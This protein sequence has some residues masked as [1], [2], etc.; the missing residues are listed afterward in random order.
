MWSARSDERGLS[1]TIASGPLQQSFSGTSPVGLMTIFYCLRFETPPR[2]RIYIP[3]KQDGPIILSGTGF[4]FVASYDSQG[5]GS[6]GSGLELGEC[7]VGH[8]PLSRL[9]FMYASF[10]IL[11]QFPSSDVRDLVIETSPFQQAQQTSILSPLQFKIKKKIQ[12]P[13]SQSMRNA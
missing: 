13:K 8:S 2:P 10:L 1:F 7:Y 11:D 4:L 12:F 3:Q 5:C 9:Y 6:G